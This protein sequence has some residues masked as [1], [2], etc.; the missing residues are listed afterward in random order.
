LRGRTTISERVR[1]L[2]RPTSIVPSTRF[3][4]SEGAKLPHVGKRV[5]TSFHVLAGASTIEP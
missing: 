5:C 4:V 2:V 3:Q 1:V